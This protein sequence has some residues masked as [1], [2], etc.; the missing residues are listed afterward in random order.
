MNPL[1]KPQTRRPDST[2]EDLCVSRDGKTVFTG[3]GRGRLVWYTTSTRSSL[4]VSQDCE[5]PLSV[6]YSDL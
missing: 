6:A 4:N 3:L 1:N 2:P 5:G